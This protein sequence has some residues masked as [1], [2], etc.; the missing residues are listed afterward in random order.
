[1]KQ[2]KVICP[3]CGT[4]IAIPEHTYTANDAVVIG[5]DSNLGTVVLQAADPDGRPALP[6]KA[7]D[8]LTAVFSDAG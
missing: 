1:M 4:E 5:K 8:R 3:N 2:T 7:K 6:N